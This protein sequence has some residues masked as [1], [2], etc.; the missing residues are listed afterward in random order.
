MTLIL[1]ET[2]IWLTLSLTPRHCD[3]RPRELKIS[4]MFVLERRKTRSFTLSLV[5]ISQVAKVECSRP[6]SDEYEMYSHD[7]VR[8]EFEYYNVVVEVAT[9]ANIPGRDSG[10]SAIVGVAAISGRNVGVVAAAVT[11]DVVVPAT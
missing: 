3:A 6:R 1:T 10:G 11:V 8:C 5:Q 2:L 7:V 9:G 4:T